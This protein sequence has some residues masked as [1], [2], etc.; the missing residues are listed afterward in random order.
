MKAYVYTV[1]TADGWLAWFTIAPEVD[2]YFWLG[3]DEEGMPHSGDRT[4]SATAGQV[5]SPGPVRAAGLPSRAKGDVMLLWREPLPLGDAQRAVQLWLAAVPLRQRRTSAVSAANGFPA[6]YTYAAGLEGEQQALERLASSVRLAASEGKESG[7]GQSKGSKGRGTRQRHDR[8]RGCPITGEPG[9]AGG[10]AGSKKRQPEGKQDRA[11]D[12]LAERWTCSDAAFAASEAAARVRAL[13]AGAGPAAA[14]LQ[15][16]A[17]LR[18]EAHAMLAGADTAHGAYNSGADGALQLA[19]LQ[20]RL[21]LTGAVAAS[22]PAA[23][24]RFALLC[25]RRRRYRCL[26][27]GSGEAH[28]RRTACASCGRMCAYCTAC[29]GMGRSRECELLVLGMPAPY[30]GGGGPMPPAAERLARWGLSPAQT[31]AAGEALRF[32]EAA[33]CAAPLSRTAARDKQ[34]PAGAERQHRYASPERAAPLSRTAAR[35]KQL[36]AGAER[37]HRYASPERAAPPVHAPVSALA[38]FTTEMAA[39]RQFLLWAV[40]GAGKTEMIFPLVESVL[41]RGGKALIATPRRDVVLELDPRIRKAFPEAT[42]VT[43]YGGSEQRWETGDITLSTTHQLLRFHQAF[44]LVIVDELDAFPYA[45]DPVLHY[46]ANK[47]CAPS[48]ARLLLSA[49]PPPSCSAPR[50]KEHC[51]MPKFRSA[52]TAIRFRYRSCSERRQCTKCCIKA[53]CP[54][55]WHRRSG[56]R[57][58]EGRSCLFLSKKLSRPSPWPCF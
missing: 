40:T 49:T 38:G 30:A 4:A 57:W 34:L 44:Q 20:G 26:R 56:S 22:A 27:C 7:G 23:S 10:S 3:G 32:V 18:G 11:A 33:P 45:G 55:S 16:R 9:P 19:A 8:G 53:S 50:V 54:P 15:G 2:R 28:M 12:R 39:P 5:E 48:A 43:L 36:P 6:A 46:A 14:A 29:L 51:R 42:V 1:F 25:Q 21:R 47:C 52:T 17:L 35:D 31:A 58:N 41:R 24:R 13:A 37:Q